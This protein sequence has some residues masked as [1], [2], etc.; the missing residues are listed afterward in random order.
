[1]RRS[2]NPAN[3]DAIARVPIARAAPG[4]GLYVS[5]AVVRSY[6]GKLRFE[7]TT[8]GACFVIEL[9]VVSKP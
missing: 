3:A 4:L 8:A 9:Q 5:R 6:G 1:M 7:P 2:F